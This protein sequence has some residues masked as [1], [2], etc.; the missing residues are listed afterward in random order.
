MM[1]VVAV[2]L[3]FGFIRPF[4]V[5]PMSVPSA[6][7]APTLEPGDHVLTNKLVYDFADPDRGISWSSRAST[8][9]RTK[10]S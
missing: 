9:V 5:E 6:S 8:S 7:M 4:V 3:V 10:R 2:D 1:L